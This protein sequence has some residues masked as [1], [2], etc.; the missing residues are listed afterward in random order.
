[1]SPLDLGIIGTLGMVVLLFSGIPVALAMGVIGFVGFAAVSGPEPAMG[2]LKT[3][4]YTTVSDY[5]MSV[6]PLFVLIGVFSPGMM[7]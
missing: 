2:L 1:M 7:K 5:S 3:V 6:V 4:P